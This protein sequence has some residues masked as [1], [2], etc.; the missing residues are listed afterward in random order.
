MRPAEWTLPTTAEQ[1]DEAGNLQDE[2]ER[3]EP[4]HRA[5]HQTL[6]RGQLPLAATKLT[7]LTLNSSA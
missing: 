2:H 6:E 1:A 3:R 5:L 7:P 4:E